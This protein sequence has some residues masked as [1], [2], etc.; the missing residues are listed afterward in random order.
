M[1]I[2]KSFIIHKRKITG[3]LTTYLLKEISWNSKACRHQGLEFWIGVRG[4]HTR[5]LQGVRLL[6]SFDL[7]KQHHAC[8]RCG[9][10]MTPSFDSPRGR[11][12]PSRPAECPE[13]WIGSAIWNGCWPW[14][15]W[16]HVVWKRRW[17]DGNGKK[18][19]QNKKK[20]L[21]HKRTCLCLITKEYTSSN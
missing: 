7:T 18:K 13:T 9:W 5:P 16:R 4:L 8:G 6:C 2:A 17:G 12:V 14:W 10:S 15:R 11:A 21:W 19:K 1:T 3:D 20:T